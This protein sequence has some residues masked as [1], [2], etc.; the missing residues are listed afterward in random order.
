MDFESHFIES[1]KNFRCTLDEHVGESL[2]IGMNFAKRGTLAAKSE[3][4]KKWNYLRFIKIRL[5]QFEIW[6]SLPLNGLKPI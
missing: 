6:I 2:L 4:I 1:V 5:D 3:S